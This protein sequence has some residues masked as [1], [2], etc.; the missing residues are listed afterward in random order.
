MDCMHYCDFVTSNY[1]SKSSLHC[2]NSIN[3]Y[4]L[5]DSIKAH[6]YPTHTKPQQ[7]PTNKQTNI[8]T[9]RHSTPT[10]SPPTVHNN[11]KPPMQQPCATAMQEQPC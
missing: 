8:S 10:S 9:T 4:P 3:G 11:P 1:V 6:I 2:I 7:K 5:G